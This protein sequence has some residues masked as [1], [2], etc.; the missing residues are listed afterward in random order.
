MARKRR[1]TVR[2]SPRRS[3]KRTRSRRR[4]SGG[5]Y[6]LKNF[7]MKAGAG[8]LYGAGREYVS[9]KMEP[10][11]TNMVGSLGGYAD[12][13]GMLAASY[14]LGKQFPKAR[15]VTDA[16]AYIEGARIGQKL[17]GN[18]MSNNKGTS[19]STGINA[20]VYG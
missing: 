6:N 14:L 3:T 20:N 9:A 13:A 19:N 12:E 4:S 8:G 10:W 1:R 5:A 2:A 11:V 7:G 18:R 16:A 17:A 15:K